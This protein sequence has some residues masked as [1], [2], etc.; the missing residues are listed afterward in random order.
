MIGPAL[1]A[2]KAE[3]TGAGFGSVDVDPAVLHTSPVAV[4]LQP[5]TIRG[6]RLGGGGTLTA[7]AYL[8]A[9]NLDTPQ[10]ITLL[11]DA[12]EA[13]LALD[14]VSLSDDDDA[15]DLAAAVLLPHTTTPLPAYRLALDIE[16]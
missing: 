1:A 13:V 7:W 14:A 8:I 2:L 3:L 10:V 6:W 4:W 5:R 9:S 15:V 11:D 12:L 16:L